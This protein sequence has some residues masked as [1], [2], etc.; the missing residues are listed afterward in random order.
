MHQFVED[1]RG[2]EFKTIGQR[3]VGLRCYCNFQTA[4]ECDD[5]DIVEC[6]RCGWFEDEGGWID[7]LKWC[8]YYLF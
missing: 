1:P 4:M 6:C 8:V 5:M 7:W 3:G 2:A